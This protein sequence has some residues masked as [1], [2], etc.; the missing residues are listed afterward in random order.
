MSSRS[1]RRIS[2]LLLCVS[3]EFAIL[4]GIFFVAVL[5]RFQGLPTGKLSHPAILWSRALLTAFV[6]VGC[7]YYGDLYEEHARPRQSDLFIRLVVSFTAATLLLTALFYA[8]PLLQVGRG[9]VLIYLPLA[10][11]AIFAWRVVFAWARDN[12]AL[13][14]RVMILGTGQI[15]Q[16]LGREM[17]QRSPVGFRVLGFLSAR[18]DEV[19]QKLVGLPVIGTVDNVDRFA[20]TGQAT[21]IVVAQEDLRGHL[22]IDALLRCRLRGIGVEEANSFYERL[23]GKILVRDLRPSSLVF[24]DGFVRPRLLFSIKRLTE[25]FAAASMLVIA[26]PLMAVLALFVWMDTPGPILYRQRRVGVGG[27]LFD[28]L[29]F[30]SMKASAEISSGPVWSSPDGDARVTR[31]GRVLRKLRLDE[32]PQLINVVRGEMSFVGPRPERPEFVQRLAPVIPYYDER[33][34]VYP[35][36]TGWAQIN[37]PYGSTFEDAEE[38]LEYDLYYVKHMSLAFD[39]VIMLKTVKVMLMGRGAR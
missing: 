22:P 39:A 17:R 37:F 29:K 21:L 13:S 8:V 26:A 36:I 14:E 33:H 38:K 5:I 23:T 30:R 15:A 20:A 2:P 32:L 12:E 10:L 16:S 24:A 1:S 35:G 34:T 18:G 31:L 19:D 25:V 3:A 11:T 27:R 7:L 6:V 9:I 28:L 4:V